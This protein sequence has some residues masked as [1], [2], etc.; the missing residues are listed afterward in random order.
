MRRLNTYE[1]ST[2]DSGW[3]DLEEMKS[4]AENVPPVMRTVGFVLFETDSHISITESLGN[5]VCGHVTKV[6]TGMIRDLEVLREV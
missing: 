1:A 2:G 3:Q 6:P 5:D 4:R